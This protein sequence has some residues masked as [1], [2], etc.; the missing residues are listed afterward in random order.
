MEKELTIH[1]EELE[2]RI[3]PGIAPG[4]RG[5][6]GQPGNQGNGLNGYEGQPGNQGG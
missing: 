4:L 2:D 3:A 1:I 6:E 5:Y